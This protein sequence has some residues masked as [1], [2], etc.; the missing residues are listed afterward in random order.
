MAASFLRAVFPLAL[1][2]SVLLSLLPSTIAWT[3]GSGTCN[4][5]ASSVTSQTGR[6]P[7]TPVLGFYLTLPTTYTPGTPLKLSLTNTRSNPNITAFNGFL[8]YATDSRGRRVGSFASDDTTTTTNMVNAV[9]AA[10]D[11][12]GRYTCYDAPDATLTHANGGPKQLPLAL[13]WTP[14]ATDVGNITFSGLVEYSNALFYLQVLTPW[15]VCSPTSGSCPPFDPS[16]LPVG[17]LPPPTASNSTPAGLDRVDASSCGPFTPLPYAAVPPGYCVSTYATLNTPR[18]IFVTDHGD[19]LVAETGST[20]RLTSGVTLLRDLDGDGVIQAGTA[21]QVRVWNQTGVYHGLYVRA[22]WMYVSSPSTTWRVRFNSSDPAAPLS[23]AQV[24]VKNI[25]PNHHISR[26]TLMSHDAVWLYVTL[27]SG[28]NVDPDDSRARVVRY[29]VSGD[30]PD[31][32]FE[33]DGHNYTDTRVQPFAPGL[34]NEVGLTLDFS[35]VVWGVMNGD[36]ELNRT[37]LGGY[38]IHNDNP[39]ER[40]DRLTEAVMEQKGWYGYPQCW[41]VDILANHTRG[42]LFVWS[43]DGTD[44]RT[45]GYTDEWCRSHAIPPTVPLQAHTAP[46]G[47]V[48]YDGKGRYGFPGEMYNQV[49]ISQHGSWDAAVPRGYKVSRVEWTEDSAGHVSATVHDFFAYEGP[50]AISASWPHKPVDVRIGA[51]GELFVSSDTS[52]SI[53]AIRHLNPQHRPVL[54]PQIAPAGFNHMMV[55]GP[56]LASAEFTFDSPPSTKSNSNFRWAAGQGAHAGLALLDGVN[57]Y[58]NASAADSGAGTAAPAVWGGEMSVE[59]VFQVSNV[60]SVPAGTLVVLYETVTMGD[61]MMMG[62]VTLGYMMSGGG[63]MQAVWT[64]MAGSG[65]YQ[66]NHSIPTAPYPAWTYLIV[67]MR[68]DPSTRQV[69]VGIHGHAMDRTVQVYT[70][71]T[72]SLPAM[73]PRQSVIGRSMALAQ[74]IP[75]RGALDTLRLYP[76]ALTV[77]AALLQFRLSDPAVI[78]PSVWAHFAMQPMESSEITF[79]HQGVASHVGRASPIVQPVPPA[80]DLFPGWA[81]FDGVGEYIDLTNPN[82]GVGGWWGMDAARGEEELSMEVWYRPDVAG[83]WV[84][85]DAKPV[86]LVAGKDAQTLAINWT[87]AG[88]GPFGVLVDHAVRVGEWT[89]LVWTSDAVSTTVYLNGVQVADVRGLEGPVNQPPAHALLG[90]PAAGEEGGWYAGSIGAFRVYPA[91]LSGEQVE[92][93]YAAQMDHLQVWPAD[94]G[95]T[96]A[97]GSGTAGSSCAQPW[98]PSSSGGDGADGGL[99][100]MTVAVVIGIALASIAVLAVGYFVYKRK[101]EGQAVGRSGAVRTTDDRRTALLSEED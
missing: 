23:G 53:L 19:L 62:H 41:A 9:E 58:I 57:Q 47:L 25:P 28:S 56:T 18:S 36:D 87:S 82:S 3:T 83:A 96:G 50:G 78:T 69:Q 29:N 77:H 64:W 91:S 21:E 30:I 13:T 4:A 85:L 84:L 38:A 7:I 8:L 24:V 68:Q 55:G 45:Q 80:R 97:A 42:E 74:S 49:L 22:G 46:I 71:V 12:H 54:I 48:F 59:V 60:S 6:H 63:E 67:T 17:P 79:T 34:R 72:G 86:L 37:D 90:R 75:F 89:H 43:G 16:T 44:W 26:T 5:T 76:F 10:V 99:S 11:S 92:T 39:S 35:K 70:N 1:V 101:R 2:F 65:H 95:S 66:V 27:G 52:S 31:G 40:L 61:E 15:A 32:G 93:L 81:H 94:G 51:Q 98:V 88:A 14:P 100:T 20:A 73:L 33:W